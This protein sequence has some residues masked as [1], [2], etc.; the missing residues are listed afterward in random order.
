MLTAIGLTIALYLVF[1][2]TKH[3]IWKGAYKEQDRRDEA[4]REKQ[5][6]W[7]S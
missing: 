7:R 4:R 3:L 1:F 2:G 6:T 5:D